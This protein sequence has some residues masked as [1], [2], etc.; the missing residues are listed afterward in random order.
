MYEKLRWLEGSDDG[1]DYRNRFQGEAM[2][3]SH[4][5]W[6]QA[7]ERFGKLYER[8]D[9]IRSPF[10]R[11]YARILHC[12]AYR[13][14]KHKTQVFFSP[15]NDH[16]CTRIEHVNHVASVSQTI[17]KELGLNVELVQAIA[18]GHDVG[19]AP[20][21]HE[22]EK[23][24]SDLAAAID[25]R[26]FWHERHSL[27]VLDFIEDLTGPDGQD[28]P[29]ALT[30]A[31]R[32]GIAMHCG[33]VH[34]E[35]LKP[36]GNC[37][38]LYSV[39][40]AGDT[41][42]YTWEGCVVKLADKIAYLGRDIED[43]LTLQ[44]IR[45]EQTAGLL[46]FA[47]RHL[48]CDEPLSI[49]NSSLIHNFTINVCQTSTPEDGIGLAP[50][51]LAFMKELAD[52][53]RCHIY[54]HPRLE[55]YKKYARLILSSIYEFLL[56]FYSGPETVSALSGR[57]PRPLYLTS[58]FVEYLNKKIGGPEPLY[59]LRKESAYREACL[60]YLAGMTDNFAQRCFREIISFA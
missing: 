12:R 39:A 26:N 3:P 58:Y 11:D 60:D 59:D 44:I 7:T 33:E 51:Y 38:D 32:D 49:T 52:F 22:G 36:R 13:R 28:Q 53:S 6:R 45:S 2:G 57:L 5:N 46:S 15:D 50:E 4:P 35:K 29:L 17:A 9:D 27:R 47:R 18:I 41:P 42:A 31:V 37:I 14:L 30:Y 54:S 48:R 19:H 21:G 24:L 20:F 8:S 34:E 23:I 16:I 56:E 40:K 25:G 1:M 10:A 55:V 43:A